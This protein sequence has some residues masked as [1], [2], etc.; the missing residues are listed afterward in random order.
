MGNVPSPSYKQPPVIETVLGVSFAPIKG[1][2][3]P[4]LGLF[5]SK[6]R[7]ELPKIEEQP[8]LESQI[9][10][11]SSSIAQN[12]YTVTRLQI[13][14]SPNVR[15]WYIDKTDHNLIQLQKDRFLFNW[16]KGP[17]DTEYPR[18]DNHL[19]PKFEHFWNLFLEFL[20]E[21]NLDKPEVV[22][23]EVTYFNHILRDESS[24][25]WNHIL[26]S[27]SDSVSYSFLPKTEAFHFNQSFYFADGNGRLR[28]S[29]NPGVRKADGAEVF[30][31]ELTARGNPAG[32]DAASILKW[33]DLGHTWVVNG[34]T[35]LTTERMHRI[36]EREQ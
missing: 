6:V 21:Q 27:L 15:C 34:F 19:K 25:T 18:Y 36:W 22:Q 7:N 5:W 4:Y 10:S 9:E 12:P 2:Q 28:V 30:V 13:S 8:P 35:D 29:G 24:P 20:K 17:S 1:W 3:T 33:F 11:E 26:K 23:A 32:S 14:N 16:R 31:L